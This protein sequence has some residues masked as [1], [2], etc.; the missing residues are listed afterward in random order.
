MEN[1]IRPIN[2]NA[3]NATK[4]A[5]LLLSLGDTTYIVDITTSS[6]MRQDYIKKDYNSAQVAKKAEE[7]KRKSYSNNFDIINIPE[8]IKFVAFG[9]DT[10]GGWGPEAINFMKH[11]CNQFPPDISC[12]LKYKW[13]MI[14]STFIKRG[15]RYSTEKVKHQLSYRKEALPFPVME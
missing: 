1:G 9:I 10:L 2:N 3:N 8:G 13:K 11:I 7:T 12:R 6:N 5:D 14:I 15:Q 4:R